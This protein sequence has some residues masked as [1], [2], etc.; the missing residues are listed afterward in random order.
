LRPTPEDIT[1][2]QSLLSFAE[3]VDVPHPSDPGRRVVGLSY[4][5]AQFGMIT[6]LRALGVIAE[7][8]TLKK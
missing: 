6:A 4:L 1:A 7:R 3:K 8:A 2:V 5:E